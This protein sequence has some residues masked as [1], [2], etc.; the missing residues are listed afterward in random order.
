MAEL[1]S[2]K[3]QLMVAPLQRSVA[4]ALIPTGW[5]VV[6]VPGTA[7]EEIVGGAASNAVTWATCGLPV[8][9]NAQPTIALASLSIARLGI[10]AEP[11]PCETSS[12]PPKLPPGGRV[13][14]WT[15]VRFCDHTATAVP[16]GSI[17]TA[18]SSV[19]LPG[20]EIVCGVPKLARD[21][22]AAAFVW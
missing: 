2:P 10:D 19:E 1:P 13:A 7:T 12:T 17:A 4:A 6:P 3:F 9:L 5:P 20:P 21:A 16:D 11:G 18:G 22:R 8:G 14:A 15:V